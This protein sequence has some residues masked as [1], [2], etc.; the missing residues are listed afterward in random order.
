MYALDATTGAL[1]WKFATG[2]VVHAS[3]AVANGVVYIGSWDRNMYALDAASG[4]ERW[5]FQTGNDTTIHNQIGIA[6]SAA[7]ANGT[8][9]FGCRDGHFYAVDADDGRAA[10]GARQPHGL[11]DCVARGEQRRRLLSDGRRNALQG[12]G[13]GDRR[14][15]IQRREQSDFVLVTGD[16]R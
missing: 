3:P 11:G 13:C 1:R 9:Y 14:G 7:V 15:E 5:R 16:R 4:T 12:A 10:L 2:D 8:V 6:S